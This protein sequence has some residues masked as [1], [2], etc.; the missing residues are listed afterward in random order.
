MSNWQ[1][2]QSA[3]PLIDTH[4]M[5]Q[6]EQQ[7]GS[8]VVARLLGVFIQEGQQQKT[9]LQQAVMVGEYQA[10]A[11]ICHSLK[12]ACGSYGA[13]RCQYLSEKLE[14]AC[15]QQQLDQIQVLASAWLQAWGETLVLLEAP[16]NER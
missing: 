14:A 3:L 8:A 2:L 4:Q 13:L 10:V 16:S 6:L 5:Q 1:R 12:S 7:L 9:L 15:R 11:R